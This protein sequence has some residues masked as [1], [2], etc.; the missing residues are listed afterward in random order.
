MDI[1][2]SFE[3]DTEP[4]DTWATV[5][6]VSG[7]LLVRRPDTAIE[8]SSRAS[9]RTLVGR[10]NEGGGNIVG[11]GSGVG[12]GPGFFF[13]KSLSSPSFLSPVVIEL[14][15]SLEELAASWLSMFRVASKSSCQVKGV[16]GRD[17]ASSVSG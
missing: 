8:I 15:R 11:S 7:R 3:P 1:G 16:R 10:R 5:A 14:S 6:G 12:S 13:L 9:M 4:E 2:G 17:C